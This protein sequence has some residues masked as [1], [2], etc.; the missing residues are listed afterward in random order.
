MG[1]TTKITDKMVEDALRKTA[2]IRTAASKLLGMSESAVRMR[3]KLSERLQEVIKEIDD[4]NLDIAE[5]TVFKS[6][7]NAANP[8]EQ[9]ET[10]KWYL[11]YRG[12]SRGYGARAEVTGKDGG[13]INVNSGVLIVPGVKSME[14]WTAIAGAAKIVEEGE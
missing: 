3:I 2:G 9:L 6:L 14:E 1:R 10:A 12:G 8:M 5:T 7:R 11:R 13:P 4:V